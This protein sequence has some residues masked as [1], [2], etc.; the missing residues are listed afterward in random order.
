[1]V[2]N[3]RKELESKFKV[4]ALLLLLLQWELLKQT[5]QKAK[6]KGEHQILRRESEK[7]TIV[8]GKGEMWGTELRGTLLSPSPAA[9]SK[10]EQKRCVWL[11][12]G[13]GQIWMTAGKLVLE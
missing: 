9:S 13:G 11:L 12:V 6:R 7:R 4:N 3:E 1:M 8:K 5:M 2:V 10:A